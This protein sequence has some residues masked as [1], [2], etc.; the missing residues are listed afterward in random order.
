MLDRVFGSRKTLCTL[1]L[2]AVAFCMTALASFATAPVV[3]YSGLVTAAR[4]EF[5]SGFNSAAPVVIVLLA[6]CLAI[7]WT[8]KMLKRSVKSA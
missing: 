3:D 4:D 1:V 2:S 7:R 8:I 5:V 6:T